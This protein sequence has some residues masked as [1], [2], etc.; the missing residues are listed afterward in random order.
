I[1]THSDPSPGV[2]ADEE[3]SKEAVGDA[4]LVV[5]AVSSLGAV[6]LETDAW[7][8]DLVVSR[9]QKALRA[10]R[11]LS[12]RAEALRPRPGLAGVGARGAVLAKATRSRSFSFDGPRNKKAQDALDA[13]FT[14]AV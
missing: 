9:S 10:P 14:P 12:P 5:D 6:P 13:A 7:G 1:A 11:G 4:T 3:A 2:V 8:I